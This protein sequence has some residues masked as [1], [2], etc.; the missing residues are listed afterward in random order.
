MTYMVYYDFKMGYHSIMKPKYKYGADELPIL[1]TTSSKIA[2][3]TSERLNIKLL[4][5]IEEEI[6]ERTTKRRVY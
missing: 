4:N 1:K 3:E 6:N 5:E 2:S